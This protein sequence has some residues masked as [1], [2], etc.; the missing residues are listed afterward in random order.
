MR[1]QTGI[2]S[3]SMIRIVGLLVLAV[4]FSGSPDALAQTQGGC[5]LPPD[6][7]P[8]ADPAVTAQQVEDG[9]ASLEDF[10]L[11]VRE[12]SRE[13]A[14]GA[15]TNEGGVYIGCIIRRDD[16]I[17]RSGSTYIVSLTLDGRLYI[18]AKDM[19]LSGRQLN[20]LIYG[21]I[22]TALGVSPADLVNLQS[23]DPAVFN[24]AYA[25]L[26]NTLSQEPDGAF[27]A[28][29]FGVPG[30]SGH[31][32]VYV[33]PNLGSPIVLLV[34]FDIDES[35]LAQEDIDYGDPAITAS[36]VVDRET[37]KAFVTQAGEYLLE[38]ME[39]GDAAAASKARIALRDPNGPWR[40]GSVYLYILDLT[41]NTILF[42]AAFPDKYEYRPLIPTVQDAVTGEF[43]L[44][45]VIEA[46]KGNPEGGFVE[47]YFD[48]PTDDTDSAD[49]PKVGYA[50]EFAAEIQRPDGSVV[51]ADFII[52]S[53]F[54]GRAPDDV[55]TSSCPLPDG[56]TPPADPAVTAQQVVDGSASL[57]DFALAARDRYKTPISPPEAALYFQ[58]LVRQEGGPYR[59]GSTYLVQLTLDGRVYE[60][61][62]SMALSGRLLNPLIYAEILTALG[63]SPAD[64]VNLQS[65]DPAI[66][67]AAYAALINI[68]SQEP[69]AAFDATTPIPGLRP[70][71]PGA[72]GHATVYLLG[73]PGL[74]ILLLTGFDINESHLIKETIDYGNPTITAKDVVDR[75]TLKAFVTQ[76][77]EWFVPLVETATDPAVISKVRIAA[78]D[79]NGPWRHGSVYL[80]VLDLTSN[81]IL[82]HGAFPDRFEWRPLVATVRDAVTGKLVLPQVIEAAKSSPEGGFVEYYFDDPTDDTDRADIPKVGYARQFTVSIP[83][84]DGTVLPLDVIIG[85]GFY[86]DPT[87]GTGRMTSFVPVVLNTAGRK[88]SLFTSEMTL[89]NRGTQEA[90]LLYRYTAH[91]GGGSGTASDTLAAGA[92][93]IESDAIGYLQTLGVPL[94]DSGNRIGTLAVEVR[95][96]SEVGVMVRTTTAVPEG[97]AGLAYPGIGGN[98][99]F[100]E[101]VYLS[102]LRQNEQDRS[103]VA[104]QNMGRPGEGSIT[105]RTT[106]YSGDGGDS[107][108]RVLEAVSLRPG[109]FYQYNEVLKAVLGS[110]SQGYVK[111]EK[112]EGT[113]PFYAYGVINDQVNSDG[114]FVFPVTAS[115]LAGKSGQ[116]LPVILERDGFTS[117][118]MVTNFSEEAKAV[119]FSV[120]GD[121]PVTF[122]LPLSPGQQYIIPDA[123]E[124]ARQQFGIDLPRG[125]ALPLFA[126]GVGGDLSGV[127]IGS[128]T[129]A[130]AKPGDSSGG[131]YS[132]FYAAVPEGAGFTD[133][134]WIDALQQNEEN[135]SHLALVNTGEVDDSD[136]VFDLE[137]YDGE[138]GAKVNT[139]TGIRVG[140]KRWH[141]INGILGDYAPGAMQGYVRVRKTSGNNPFLAYGVIHDGG[142]R[143]ERSDDGAYVPAR[144]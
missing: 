11:A 82:F 17:W 116:T 80:Y 131:Q 42:H 12:R 135:R 144:E 39:S 104:F 81:I 97:R 134:A 38:F 96:S 36:E 63:V 76:A 91:L 16:G 125:L 111:V 94:P 74:P 68:L 4:V 141:Q 103:N 100:Q 77:G 127:V 66:R 143:L 40:H 71:I 46:A 56:V 87:T 6:A 120:A 130:L 137:I 124:V 122:A 30:A 110:P 32:A 121:A 142:V 92:Q 47:Y 15:A 26:L 9:S 89:T 19:S 60:H 140:A 58:C 79:P 115:S 61:A 8:P 93:R 99:G 3:I 136:S 107:S 113:A 129:G 35:H 88:G 138:T 117:E 78:R 95:G 45:Q 86:G 119:S 34:G 102:G 64:L 62:K 2:T 83:R 57:M 49:I 109:G 128:R 59:S 101:A 139:L 126:S 28:A 33:S 108:P 14:R 50:R 48:D 43:I 10:A 5:Y 75:E 90:S 22:L 106:V 23:T 20:P 67:G 18:H 54:Y 27:D 98:E 25:A 133:S 85:S 37:L 105:V 84:A 65:P 55:T 29:I 73:N 31:S 41:T 123:L 7:T 70:G 13:Y 132:V 52:G 44:P 51:P 69:D 24:A 1:T 53:G 72:S 118:L 112:V 21:S 114:S